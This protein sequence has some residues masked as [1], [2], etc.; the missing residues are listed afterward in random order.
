[1]RR[2]FTLAAALLLPL[3]AQAQGNPT[4]QGPKAAPAQKPLTAQQYLDRM[5][6]KAPLKGTLLGVTVRTADGKTL[7]SCN[8]DLRLTPASN[9]K[10]VTTGCALHRFGADYRFETH[11]GY[12]GR[13]DE[14]GTLH[15]DLYIMGGGDPT[16]GAGDKISTPAD[17]LFGKWKKF[18]QQAGIKRI[19]GRIIGDGHAYEGHLEHASWS[20]DDLGTYYGTGMNAL[21]F[22]ENAIDFA[23]EATTEGEPVSFVQSYPETPWTH[24]ENYSFTGP[25]GSS[26]S[27]YLFTT[28]LA[29]YA[30]LRGTFA[31]DR[32]PKTEHF[33][34]KF[35]DLSCAYEFF[36]SLQA[37]S[38]EV[39]GGYARVNRSGHI[40]GPDFVWQEVA[41]TPDAVIGRTK[42]PRLED[43]AR[44]TNWRSDNFYAEALLRAMGEEASGIAVYDSCAVALKSTLGKLK[45]RTDGIQLADGSGLSRN[46]YLSACWLADFLDAMKT[47]PAFPAFLGSLPA[48]GQ[49][50]LNVVKLGEGADRIRMKS[51]S[52]NGVLC[53]SGYI[54]DE[55]GNPS[56]TFSILTG[57]ATASVREVRAALVGFL[58]FL[59][60]L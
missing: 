32:K 47:S 28:D 58:D 48:P 27:L 44:E 42:S 31:T 22:Y 2:F 43:I 3:M 21:C 11:L 25:A 8:Q 30:E 6:K 55:E 7:A 10:L 51:G 34:N 45:M 19:D 1:M 17:A 37:D 24:T 40:E 46:N 57:N 18:L 54:L 39:T 36:K 50:T 56:L 16:T 5:A 4:G 38:L 33:A 12:T 15:G 49:G 14:N 41:A 29:P 60:S 9:L 59:L 53:Y 26:N 13:I 23:V 35:G 52:M 20:Y